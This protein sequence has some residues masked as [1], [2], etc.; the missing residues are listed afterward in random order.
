MKDYIVEADYVSLVSGKIKLTPEQY[1]KREH[2]LEKTSEKD[3]YIIKSSAG[4][5]KGEV[6]SLDGDTYSLLKSGAL[7]DASPSEKPETEDVEVKGKKV[8]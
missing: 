2:A 4:F 3:V 6:F 7:S 5:K 8:K 1:S